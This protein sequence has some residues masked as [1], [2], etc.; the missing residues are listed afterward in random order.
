MLEK[1]TRL[2]V[3]GMIICNAKFPDRVRLALHRLYRGAQVC[4]IGRINGHHNRDFWL[5]RHGPD[6]ASNQ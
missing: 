2:L 5:G 4:K 6:F 1:L 3:R